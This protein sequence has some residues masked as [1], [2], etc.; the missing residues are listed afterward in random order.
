[1]A[2]TAFPKIT[3]ATT[4]NYSRGNQYDMLTV[5]DMKFAIFNKPLY[6]DQISQ[7]ITF[8]ANCHCVF[9]APMEAEQDITINAVNIIAF[10]SFSAKNGST[11]IH[12]QSFYDL[13]IEAKGDFFVEADEDIII[14]GNFGDSHLYTKGRHVHAGLT[15]QMSEIATEVKKLLSQ[16]IDETNGVQ[17]VQTLLMGAQTLN[18][19][20]KQKAITNGTSQPLMLT[21]I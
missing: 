19:S 10:G 1:M 2:L 8:D 7:S 13:G 17:F 9:L 12:A 16:G 6:A 18:D 5:S 3:L 20:N 15:E 4:C 11:R 14:S 21:D